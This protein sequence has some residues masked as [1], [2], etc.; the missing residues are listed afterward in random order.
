[1][2]L[3]ST[4][5]ALIKREFWEHRGAFVK[6]PIIVGIVFLVFAIGGYITA[7]VLTKKSAAEELINNLI[8]ESGGLDP[9]NLT[10]LWNGQMM[11]L[12]AMYLIILYFVL[13]FFLL[14]SLFDDRK[15]QSILFWKSLPISDTT[16]V[17]SKM[18]T[19]MIF[20]PLVFVGAFMVLMLL[21]M[22]IATVVMLIHGLN[23][24][25]LIWSPASLFEGGKVMM[26]GIMTQMLWA[27]PIYGWLI[28]SSS[29]SKRRPFLFAVFVPSIFA[30]SWYW[31]NVLTFKFT[32]VSMFK[33]PLNYIGHAFLPY[34]SGS[35]SGR[36]FHFNPEESTT[37]MVINNMLSSLNSIEILYGALF[38]TVLVSLAIW[39]RR[40]RNT[41]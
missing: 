17:I 19:A 40:Y 31:I 3:F 38:C 14:G 25:Q 41:I 35:I 4:Y 2:N 21:L 1:M 34:G 32:N 18:I 7:I 22:V 24:I 39:L 27:L 37:D 20:V 5:K 8:R 28:F 23:P 16:T 13:F 26:I 6:T 11:G 9:V 15:D 12:S 33:E 10:N 30:L 36:N 29:I